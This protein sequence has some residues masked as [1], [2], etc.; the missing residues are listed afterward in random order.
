MSKES[1][2]KGKIVLAVDDEHD[3]LETIEAVLDMCI[4]DKAYDY[5]EASQFLL[6]YTYDVVVLDIMGV[7]GFE[8]L[9]IAASRNFPA[10]ILTAHAFTSRVAACSSHSY[11]TAAQKPVIVQQFCQTRAFFTLFC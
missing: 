10:V 4:V 3:T 9:K 2:L 8:L 5:N 7:N 11:Q 1:I 6:T